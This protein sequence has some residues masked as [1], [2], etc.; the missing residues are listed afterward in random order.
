ML[1]ECRKIFVREKDSFASLKALQVREEHLEEVRETVISLSTLFDNYIKPTDRDKKVGI[2]IYSTKKRSG[3]EINH[4][5]K[6]LA[7]FCN[8]VIMLGYNV[9][10]FPMELKNTEP[11]DRKM[12]KKIT[13]KISKKEKY[14]IHDKDLETEHHI[15]A[16][17]TCRLF[18]GHK[19]HSV[20]FALTSGTP[21]I[22]IEYHPKTRNF[23]TQ[24]DSEC[25]SINDGILT[26]DLLKEKF[27]ALEL[28]LDKV[29]KHLYSTA[30]QFSKELETT[31]GKL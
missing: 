12:I 4:Y 11:D 17:S 15:K 29:G 2:A 7:D 16:V 18:V 5:I 28:E 21:L 8:Y 10:F 9:E 14:I 6:S 23:M 22:A 19:T 13:A 1:N 31:V 27:H 20:V 24:F 30:I 26:I 25:Y 3:E